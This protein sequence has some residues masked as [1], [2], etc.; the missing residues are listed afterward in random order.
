MINEKKER[1]AKLFAKLMKS[2]ADKHK[3]LKEEKALSFKEGWE[4][5]NAEAQSLY[6]G[7]CMTCG[8]VCRECKDSPE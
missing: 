3:T 4:A 2:V 8:S 1:P 6:D 7:T 5:C